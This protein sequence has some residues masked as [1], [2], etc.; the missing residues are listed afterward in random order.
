MDGRPYFISV[1]EART[2]C[3]TTPVQPN[4]EHLPLDRCIGRVLAEDLTSKVDDPP[5]DNSAMDGF[6]CKFDSEATYPLS[7]NIV[8]LQAATGENEALTLWVGEGVPILTG[9]PMPPGADAILPIERCEV[10][11]Q[12]V[13]LLEPPKPHFVRKKGENLEQG[14]VALSKGQHLTPSRVGLCATM[15]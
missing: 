2:I 7:L 6:A 12:Y 5:F 13:R 1:E 8:G 4:T 9:A 15:G 10:T 14:A 11:G 3:N